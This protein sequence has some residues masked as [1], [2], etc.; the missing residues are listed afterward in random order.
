MLLLQRERQEYFLGQ[1]I[2][3]SITHLKVIENQSGTMLF[4]SSL[5]LR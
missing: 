5:S 3:C 1:K 4:G 2:S